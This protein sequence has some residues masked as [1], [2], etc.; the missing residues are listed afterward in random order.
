MPI[1]RTSQPANSKSV[2]KGRAQNKE[3]KFHLEMVDIGSIL[4]WK[5]NPKSPALI[6]SNAK[7]MVPL[8]QQYGVQSPLVVWKKD[9]MVRKG[10]T[11]LKAL[12]M[13]GYK[14]VPVAWADFKNEHEAAAYA[15]SDNNAGAKS[16]WDPQLL[17]RL[18]ESKGLVDYAGGEDAFRGMTAFTEKDFRTVMKHTG[19]ALPS[20]LPDVDIQGEIG[21]KVGFLVLQFNSP[22][23]LEDFKSKIGLVG[24]RSRILTYTK[25]KESM[26]WKPNLKAA[27][28]KASVVSSHVRVNKRG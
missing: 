14:K 24:D 7:E 21:D 10:N 4:P 18:M 13:M 19:D 8:L 16:A 1:P 3:I 22:K 25:L 12:Q 17:K 26:E 5:D 28:V 15:L 6:L 20:A 11:T 23:E 2:S 9:R 27:P